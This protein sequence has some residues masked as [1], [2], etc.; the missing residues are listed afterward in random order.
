VTVGSRGVR[1][2][3]KLS[4][5]PGRRLVTH[6]RPKWGGRTRWD[7]GNP[8]SLILLALASTKMQPPT[9]ETPL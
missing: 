2:S 5:S 3:G 4:T 8:L 7:S 6:R 9:S 1:D